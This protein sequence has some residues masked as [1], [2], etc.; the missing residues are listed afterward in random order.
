MLSYIIC[1][2]FLMSGNKFRDEKDELE[3]RGTLFGS[4]MFHSYVHV[5]ARNIT[6]NITREK[7]WKKILS[8]EMRI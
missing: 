8:W 3:R 2:C 1:N 7:G 4:A 6:H 5:K